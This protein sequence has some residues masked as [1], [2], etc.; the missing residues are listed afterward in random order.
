MNLPPD[1]NRALDKVYIF[2]FACTV[3]LSFPARAILT[4]SNSFAMCWPCCLESTKKSRGPDYC[5]QEDLRVSGGSVACWLAPRDPSK[6]DF[7]ANT[8]MEDAIDV[9]VQMDDAGD[10]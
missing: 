3:Q 10:A 2:D 1:P 7:A 4:G 9:D 5:S 8:R 6:L